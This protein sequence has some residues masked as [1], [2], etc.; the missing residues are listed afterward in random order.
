M[1]HGPFRTLQREIAAWAKEKGWDKPLLCDAPAQGSFLHNTPFEEGRR[2]EPVGVDHD[3]IASKL[4]L[5]H[6]EVSEALEA[7]REG[8]IVAYMKDGKPEGLEI[9]LADTIIRILH[10]AEDLGLDMDEAVKCKMAFNQKR[11]YMHGGKAI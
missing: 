4:A 7:L 1:T 9:E 10:L 2:S 5:V 6:S 8:H 11:S 3:R